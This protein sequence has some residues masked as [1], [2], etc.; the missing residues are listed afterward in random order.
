LERSRTGRDHDWWKVGHGFNHGGVACGNDRQ[1]VLPHQRLQVSG[2]E[3]P[4]SR[5]SREQ[6]A[7]IVGVGLPEGA[8]RYGAAD[9]FF[10]EPLFGLSADRVAVLPGLGPCGGHKLMDEAVSAQCELAQC[11]AVAGVVRLAQLLAE[12]GQ[13]VDGVRVGSDEQVREPGRVG[14]R[15]AFTA[16]LSLP[17]PASLACW[18]SFLRA[19]VKSSGGNP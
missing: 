16:A 5:Q 14:F 7:G 9:L 10:D 2:A 1:I 13:V 12:L 6:E 18:A 15:S 3:W 11:P 8:D 17:S 19:A 4:G